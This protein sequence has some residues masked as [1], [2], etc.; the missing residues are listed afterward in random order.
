[1]SDYAIKTVL[2]V[3]L[4]GTGLCAFLAMMARFGRPGDEARSERLRRLHKKAGWAFVVILA[5]LAA[6]GANFL[7][8]IGDGLPTRGAFH[9]VLAAGLVAVLLVKLLIVKAYR[10]QLRF[11]PALGMTVFALTLVIFLITAGYFVL[12]KLL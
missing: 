2:A 8:E 3:V 1:M 11:A 4:L 9:F 7:V 6:L 12:I 10:Q 5:P